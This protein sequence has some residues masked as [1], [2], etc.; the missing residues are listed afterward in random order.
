MRPHP[1]P[2]PRPP[3]PAHPAAAVFGDC[4]KEADEAMRRCGDAAGEKECGRMPD[5]QWDETCFLS[6]AGVMAATVGHGS[7]AEAVSRECAALRTEK[8]CGAAGA[9]ALDAARL[10]PLL[11]DADTIA[12]ALAV[13]GQIDTRRLR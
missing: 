2:S 7:A 5:C 6:Q 1:R 9:V 12:M 11:P 4:E 8:E 3:P 10:R 13:P